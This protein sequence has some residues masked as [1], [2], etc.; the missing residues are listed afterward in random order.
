MTLE[1]S[2]ILLLI[3]ANGV[4]AMAE[5]ALVSSSKAKLKAME[6]KGTHGAKA[7]LDLAHSPSRF[8]ST[9]Q[10]GI[11]LIGIFAGAFGGANIADRVTVYVKEIPI[12]FLVRH[13]E[14]IS[15][16]VVVV[17]IAFL[18]LVFGELIPKRLG[19]V[20]PEKISIYVAPFMNGLSRM[21]GPIVS[22]LTL[23]V[24]LFMKVF[25]IKHERSNDVSEEEVKSLIEMGMHSGV[26]K[27]TEKEMVEGVFELDQLV[28]YDLM[29]PRSKVV[30]LDAEEPDIDNWRK[31]VSSGHSHFP[32][33]KESRDNI[34]GVTSV[35]SL[36]SNLALTGKVTLLDTI[37]EPI[38]VPENMSSIKLLDTFKKSGQHF[39]LVTD[40]FGCVEGI[41]TIIDVFEAIVGDIPS[42]DEFNRPKFKK[43]ADGS[44][45]VDASIEI[46]DLKRNLKIE[47]LPD[48]DE[49]EYQTLGGLILH[50]IGKIP[51]EGDSFQILNYKFEVID[52]DRHRIDKVLVT[53]VKN[54]VEKTLQ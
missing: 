28:V 6:E 32:V 35:K 10:A 45:L 1:I 29:T 2:I 48:E 18:S 33:F 24:D 13:A 26:F 42:R 39:A 44:F 36:W 21:F 3:L 11:T 49:A 17:A 50:K 16:S 51:N 54:P 23:C 30:F 41:V 9:V 53:P 37:T 20:S 15:L 14:F 40:E 52:M 46:D 27:K 5:I 4:F 8:L 31:V 22:F 47:E 34:L 43:R 12:D 25:G 19:L 7:A 38:F